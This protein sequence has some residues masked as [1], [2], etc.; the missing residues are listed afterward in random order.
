VLLLAFL[1]ATAIVGCA[2]TDQPGPRAIDGVFPTQGDVAALPIRVSDLPGMVRTVSIV[3]PDGVPDGVS[4]VPDR[5][6]ALYLQ[7]VGGMCDRNAELV[8]ERSGDNLVATVRTERDFGGCRMAG[9]TRTLMLEFTEPVDASA[10]ELD[11]RP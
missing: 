8:V 3:A 9:I 5:D 11:V 10:V 7:W 1:L 2:S 4:Q 6:D